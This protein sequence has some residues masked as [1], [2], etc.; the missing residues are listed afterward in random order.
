MAKEVKIQVSP[1]ALKGG[2]PPAVKAGGM[3][4]SKKQGSEE[5]GAPEKQSKKQIT[6][7]QSFTLNITKMQAMNILA[8]ELEKVG[9]S[10]SNRKKVRYTL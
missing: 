4:V 3:R 6:E 7:K 10:L 9:T 8:G 1:Q 5:N 2:H